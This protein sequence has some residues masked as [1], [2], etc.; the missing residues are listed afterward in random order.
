MMV[1]DGC[2]KHVARNAT[3]AGHSAL[4][5]L[6]VFLCCGSRSDSF[7]A[8]AHPSMRWGVGVVVDFGD[9]D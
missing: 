4:G 9:L 6:I 3:A 1:V 7:E 5:N 8:S 2:R